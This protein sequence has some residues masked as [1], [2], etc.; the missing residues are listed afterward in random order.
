MFK[1]NANDPD[2]GVLNTLHFQYE[3]SP[4]PDGVSKSPVSSTL[5]AP[6]ASLITGTSALHA[7]LSSNIFPNSSAL[8]M[9][10]FIPS[11]P[12][13]ATVAESLAPFEIM[14]NGFAMSL[15]DKFCRSTER[16][17]EL[18]DKLKEMETKYSDLRDRYDELK[19]KYLS[20]LQETTRGPPTS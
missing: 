7:E 9:P 20:L 11:M 19:E 4:S 5:P 16:V 3:L 10:S 14:K 2:R 17:G 13:P 18:A 12:P 6:S 1:H 15:Y 8:P